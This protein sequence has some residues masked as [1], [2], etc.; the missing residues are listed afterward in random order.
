MGESAPRLDDAAVGQLL[1]RFDE[2]LDVVEQVPGATSE[3]AVEA[4]R[5]LAEIY[6]EGLRRVLAVAPEPLR[7]DL[8]RDQ[9]VAHLMVVH[10]IHPDPVQDRVE[11]AL[12]AVRPYIESHG[13]RV[14]LVDIDAGVA[15]VQL[16]GACGS[17]SSSAVTL[18]Q[19]VSDAVLAL[20]PELTEVEPVQPPRGG[21]T[22]IPVEALFQRPA[23]LRGSA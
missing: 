2:L 3:A 1:D 6:G 21:P 5:T 11:Q 4:I 9:L 20:A 13:G 7:A 19:T 18:E 12:D 8:A 14:E 16:S 10:D 23:A 15:H 22:V 17:C